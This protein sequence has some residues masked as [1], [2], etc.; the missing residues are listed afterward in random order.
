[1]DLPT[2]KIKVAAVHAAPVYMNKRATTEKVV[3]L[4]HEA[5]LKGIKLLVFP[6]TFIPGYPYFIMS[7]P[8]LKQVTALAQYAEQSVV[9]QGES[10]VE[11]LVIRSACQEAGVAICLGVSERIAGG[12]TLFNS[13]V[14]IDSDGELLGVHRKLQPTYAER[15]VWAQGGGVT[16][17]TY[18]YAG[19]YN[20]GALCCWENCMQLARQALVEQNEH[21]HAASWPALTAI[22]GFEAALMKSHA[23]MC[24]T[25]V[26]C[27]LCLTWMEENL[28][29]QDL[30]KRGGG[31][32]TERFVNAEI[33]LSELGVVKVWIDAAGHYKRPE[34]LTLGVDKKP[35]WA[36]ERK[37]AAGD[38]GGR[39]EHS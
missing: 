7:Y 2:L 16:L 29:K 20:L 17:R 38:E 3:R 14:N 30:I 28:G 37:Q 35:I 31:C 32:E 12:F 10:A 15:S 11:I 1:M 39:E 5:K 4:I 25:F 24:Q 19:G 22:A 27:A 6:E 34:V 23:L 33:D 21:I 13:Q 9:T 18:K 36:D 26:I 8:P